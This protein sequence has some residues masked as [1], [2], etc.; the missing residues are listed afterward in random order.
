[1]KEN[2]GTSVR[3]VARAYAI[4]HICGIFLIMRPLQ[5]C[6][7]LVLDS[8]WSMLLVAVQSRYIDFEDGFR[9]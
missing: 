9:C 8:A 7:M 4:N 1:M 3:G 2:G 6:A 5:L